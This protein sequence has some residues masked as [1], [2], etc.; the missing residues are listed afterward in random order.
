MSRPLLVR[1][2]DLFV[3]SIYSKVT[4]VVWDAGIP[5]RH[6]FWTIELV[7]PRLDVVLSWEMVCVP[8]L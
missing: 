7:F 4:V 3:W 5:A 6:V 8:P 1:S 2:S